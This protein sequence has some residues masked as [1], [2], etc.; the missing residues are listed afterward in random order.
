MF[1]IA[2]H[3]KRKLSPENLIMTGLLSLA[4]CVLAAIALPDVVTVIA[5]GFVDLRIALPI[6]IILVGFIVSVATWLAGIFR[7]KE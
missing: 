3:K 5:G 2:M 1:I 7:S 6:Y 4:L